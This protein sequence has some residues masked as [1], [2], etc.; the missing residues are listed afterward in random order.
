MGGGIQLP[1]RGDLRDSCRVDFGDAAAAFWPALRCLFFVC[2]CVQVP[3]NNLATKRRLQHGE[4]LF[5]GVDAGIFFCFVSVD[6]E[7]RQVFPSSLS[8]SCCVK[9][10]LPETPFRFFFPHVQINITDCTPCK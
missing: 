3:R 6:V 1:R 8:V 4:F 10:P 7:E 2:V 9:M 5:L